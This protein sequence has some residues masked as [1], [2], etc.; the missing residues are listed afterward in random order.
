MSAAAATKR[1]AGKPASRKEQ[2]SS[3]VAGIRLFHSMGIPDGAVLM[4]SRQKKHIFRVFRESRNNQTIRNLGPFPPGRHLKYQR[5]TLKST[6]DH[7]GHSLC[8]RKLP[9]DRPQSAQNS[10]HLRV[11]F[12]EKRQKRNVIRHYAQRFGSNSQ[13]HRD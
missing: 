4:S 7:L 12:P 11:S 10:G 2:Q 8:N 5:L 9:G 6:G 13:D 3:G 1:P